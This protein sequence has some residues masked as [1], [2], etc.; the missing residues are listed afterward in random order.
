M[1]YENLNTV[2]DKKYRKQ[3]DDKLIVNDYMYA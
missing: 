1:V 2:I 3:E